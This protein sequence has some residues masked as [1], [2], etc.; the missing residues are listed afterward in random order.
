MQ[1]NLPHGDGYHLGII[2]SNNVIRVRVESLTHIK[3]IVQNSD[4]QNE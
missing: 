3:T 1:R 2:T 4:V